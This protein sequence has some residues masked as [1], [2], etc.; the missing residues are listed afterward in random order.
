MKGKTTGH[1]SFSPALPSPPS[2]SSFLATSVALAQYS[3]SYSSK[4]A[5]EGSPDD[6][7]FFCDGRDAAVSKCFDGR[8]ERRLC[9]SAFSLV[10]L[11]C[12]LPSPLRVRCRGPSLRRKK[13]E[14]EGRQNEQRRKREAL[15]CRR[16][17]KRRQQRRVR[18]TWQ[19]QSSFVLFCEKREFNLSLSLPRLAS[20]EKE[21][22]GL[23]SFPSE[24][25]S[26]S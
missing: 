13:R 23:L 3:A 21:E 18:Y 10:C 19:I 8:A 14:K 6:I 5:V 4:S 20:R 15:C 25:L 22:R 26:L 17:G 11:L 24:V 2:P 9:L 7:V 1:R 12:L 16:V